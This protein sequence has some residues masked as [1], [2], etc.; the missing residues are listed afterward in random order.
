MKPIFKWM[1]PAFLITASL[2]LL[3]T[4]SSGGSKESSTISISLSEASPQ[5]K[6]SVSIEQLRHVIT[7]NGPSGK[8]TLSLTGSGSVRTKVAP[9]KWYID[10]AGFLGDELYSTGQANVE[11]KTGQ[12]VNVTVRM[13]VIWSEQNTGGKGG[14]GGNSGGS[15]PGDGDIGG[16]LV[17]W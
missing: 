4:C 5:G 3:G 12:T 13:T 1:L 6:A 14:G 7:L 8:K 16:I 11:V 15:A 9:G 10:A 2:L 17:T